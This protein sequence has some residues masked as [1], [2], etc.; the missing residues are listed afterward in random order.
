M[1]D[2]SDTI[3]ISG[4]QVTLEHGGHVFVGTAAEKPGIVFVRFKGPEGELTKIRL[5]AE[6][7]SALRGL[8]HSIDRDETGG[9]WIPA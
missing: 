2:A 6:A 3:T 9:E 5:S 1:S 8:L 7:A 4:N